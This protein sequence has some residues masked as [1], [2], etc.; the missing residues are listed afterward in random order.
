MK[1]VVFGLEKGFA[2]D[3]DVR[4]SAVFDS[5]GRACQAESNVILFR[6]RAPWRLVNFP[7]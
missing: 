7:F 4:I 6:T 2:A 1:I 5:A 3:F